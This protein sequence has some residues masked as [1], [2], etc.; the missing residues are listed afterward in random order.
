MKRHEFEKVAHDLASEAAA[1]IS[2][3]VKREIIARR[4]MTLGEVD[5]LVLSAAL[6]LVIDAVGNINCADCRRIAREHVEKVIPEMLRGIEHGEE[7]E[8]CGR[9]H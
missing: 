7:G 3:Y 1:T 2:D 4:K 9:V 8:Q 5:E 6:F